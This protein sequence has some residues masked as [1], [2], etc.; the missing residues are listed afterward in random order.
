[1]L[2]TKPMAGQ[3]IS[4]QTINAII[5]ELAVLRN[6]VGGKGIGINRTSS[7]ISIYSSAE[8]AK[9]GG[10]GTRYVVRI[11]GSAAGA[12]TYKVVYQAVDGS[13]SIDVTADAAAP[14]TGY[15]VGDFTAYAINGSE[16]PHSGTATGHAL[17]ATRDPAVAE[18]FI[19]GVSDDEDA[20]P[21]FWIELEQTTCD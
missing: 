16:L 2:P 8:E 4:V 14:L 12:A 9:A 11:L 20:L 10:D 13:G 21:V 15:V 3:P 19:Y 5:D 17:S 18:G 6:I 7:G 1:M